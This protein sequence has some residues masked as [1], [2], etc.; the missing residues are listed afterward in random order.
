MKE[1]NTLLLPIVMSL[2]PQVII[3]LV[4]LF[5]A[6]PPAVAILWKLMSYM[7]VHA[8]GQDLQ[9]QSPSSAMMPELTSMHRLPAEDRR[10]SQDNVLIM[11]EGRSPHDITGS[12]QQEV[13]VS[14]PRR[15]GDVSAY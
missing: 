7:R 8:T 3:A 15:I 4:G 13:C 9:P 1:A 6:I 14:W 5:L 10:T 11:E 2:S 12:P